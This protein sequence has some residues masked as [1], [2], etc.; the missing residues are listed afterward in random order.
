MA[1]DD[2][3]Q[4]LRSAHPA[5]ACLTPTGLDDRLDEEI[6]RAERHHTDLS[7]LVVRIDDVRELA[8][9]GAQL[10]DQ[11]ISYLAGALQRQLRRFD[12][13]GRP[14]EGE[15][16]VVL[17]GADQRRAETV[18]RRALGRLHAVK[19]EMDGVRRPLNVSVGI[20]AWREGLAGE[21]VLAQ[22]RRA[23]GGTS[24]EPT[25]G[26]GDPARAERARNA[27]PEPGT[28]PR[29]LRPS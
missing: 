1:A 12:R 3:S 15:L 10:P 20:A 2:S 22:A 25:G 4:M 23:A 26:G 21:D 11:A 18:A 9:H 7:C 27:H 16:A 14:S 28:A 5:R 8:S 13:V 6:G 24:E 29:A 19:L 17:P